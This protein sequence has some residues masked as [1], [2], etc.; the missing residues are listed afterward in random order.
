MTLSKIGDWQKTSVASTIVSQYHWEKD[1]DDDSQ[2]IWVLWRYREETTVTYEIRVADDQDFPDSI[3]DPGGLVSL[4]YRCESRNIN[5]PYGTPASA[6]YQEVYVKRGN[7]TNY[8][9]A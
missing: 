3:Q 4:G 1:P 8:T 2:Y 6:V 5:R 7:W 9:N